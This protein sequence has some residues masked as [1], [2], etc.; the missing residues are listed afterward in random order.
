MIALIASAAI[1]LVATVGELV[2]PGREIYHAGWYN[3]AIGALLVVNVSITRKYLRNAR[4]PHRRAAAIAVVFGAALCSL[5]GIASGLFG[6]DDQTIVGAPGQRVPVEGLGVLVFPIAAESDA[7]T[8]VSI[9]RPMHAPMEVSERTRYAGGFMLR[10]VPREVAYVEA[11]DLRG[12]HLTITQPAAAAFL[13][14][15][16]LMR[17]RQTIAGLDLPFDS[18]NVPAARRVVKALLFTRAQ[19]A[20]VL[21]GADHVGSAAVLFAVDDENDRPL[22]N[23]IALSDAGRTVRAGGLLL[24]ASVGSYPAVELVSAP[25]LAA[26]VLGTVL[27]LAGVIALLL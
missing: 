10:S 1:L 2:L 8:P 12:N 6:P 13:S 7:A 14:P 27:I 24:R 21:H 3:V 19:A 4:T 16:L 25:N 20:M 18:F 9:E 26:T 23:A 22:H 5:A 11:R 17:Q 15:V